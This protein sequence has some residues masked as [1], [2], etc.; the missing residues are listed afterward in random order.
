MTVPTSA[1][2]GIV[3]SGSTA[4]ILQAAHGNWI[5]NVRP[6]TSRGV[7]TAESGSSLQISGEGSAGIFN[8]VLISENIRTSVISVSKLADKGIYMVQ[9]ILFVC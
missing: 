4:T 9:K 5:Q 3:D 1:D 6:T 8:D 2:A 7:N